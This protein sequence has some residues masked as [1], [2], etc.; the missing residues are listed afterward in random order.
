[1][2]AVGGPEE[3]PI[4]VVRGRR[5]V[6][7]FAR[8]DSTG[9]PVTIVGSTIVAQVRSSPGGSLLWAFT[10]AV[11]S[12]SGGTFSISA[13]ATDTDVDET[14]GVW[15]LTIADD[16]LTA[17]SYIMGPVTIRPGVAA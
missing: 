9:A 16:G 6:M 5:W 12:G 4:E 15:E 3:L 14:E 10:V 1:M 11:I 17:Q 13:T 7:E 8:E 2:R